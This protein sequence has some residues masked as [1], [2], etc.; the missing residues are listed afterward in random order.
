MEGSTQKIVA[1]GYPLQV[2]AALIAILQK[3][4][5]RA[6]IQAG[7]AAYV[8]FRDPTHSRS[9]GGFRPVEVYVGENG[10]INYFTEFCYVG[11]EPMVDLAKSADFDFNEKSYQDL[12]CYN[13]IDSA[14]VRAFWKLW[15]GNF[16][17]Y[18]RM[19]VY[20]VQIVE[21]P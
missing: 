15:S 1:E 9:T 11:A 8:S 2:S 18:Y 20:T 14:D 5:D 3:E 19:G 10:R 13:S 4:I 12:S 6:G 17:E 16:V 21:G 7:V